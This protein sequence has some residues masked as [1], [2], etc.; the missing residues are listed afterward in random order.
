MHVLSFAFTFGVFYS[1]N[2]LQI[3]A[4]V[5]NIVRCFG[6]RVWMYFGMALMRSASS[7]V[8]ILTWGSNWI[9]LFNVVFLIDIKLITSP[10]IMIWQNTRTYKKPMVRKISHWDIG[11]VCI[12]IYSSALYH[13]YNLVAEARTRFVFPWPSPSRS[14]ETSPDPSDIMLVLLRFKNLGDG[15]LRR[16]LRKQLSVSKL[17]L[18]KCWNQFSQI[19]LH[20]WRAS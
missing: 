12:Y 2:W 7:S 9:Q 3:W 19:M 5:F 13:I 1:K 16:L 18:E 10:T 15:K 17:I 14:I 20:M 11:H 8:S 6:T 4:F